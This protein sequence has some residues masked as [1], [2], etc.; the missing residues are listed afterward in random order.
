MRIGGPME[1]TREFFAPILIKIDRITEFNALIDAL[2][3]A[4]EDHEMDSEERETLVSM[5]NTLSE[6]SL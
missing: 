3:S 6:M 4:V 5:C 2:E 1:V